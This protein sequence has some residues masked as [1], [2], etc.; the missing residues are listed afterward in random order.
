MLVLVLTASDR[1]LGGSLGTKVVHHNVIY[2]YTLQRSLEALKRQFPDS[3]RVIKLEG[4]CRE[5]CGEY[6]LASV[7]CRTLHHW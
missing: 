4:M 2:S 5:A 3:L 1:K 6:V 7:R